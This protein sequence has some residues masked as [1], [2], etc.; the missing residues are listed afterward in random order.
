VR[1]FS[2]EL[3]ALLRDRFPGGVLRV[4]HRTWA[5]TAESPGA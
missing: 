3:T 2:E 5:V 4:P 1:A